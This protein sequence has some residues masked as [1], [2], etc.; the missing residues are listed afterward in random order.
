MGHADLENR[1]PRWPWLLFALMTL[2]SFGGPFL[3][4]AVIRGGE[5]PDWPPDRLIEWVV[6]GG[7]VSLVVAL[8]L[9]CVGLAL[10]HRKDLSRLVAGP[11]PAPRVPPPPAS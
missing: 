5:S 4:W 7:I 6:F 8:F 11:P 3:I 9:L 2:A 10:V 1:P